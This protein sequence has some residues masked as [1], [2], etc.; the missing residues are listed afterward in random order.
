MAFP[1]TVTLEFNPFASASNLAFGIVAASDHGQLPTAPTVVTN[2][3]E[4]YTLISPHGDFDIGFWLDHE[5]GGSP[6]VAS[7]HM[8]SDDVGNRPGFIA[9]EL[10]AV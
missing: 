1:A 2:D 7:W 10:K 3:A 8:T 5:P 6:P 4:D 9:M